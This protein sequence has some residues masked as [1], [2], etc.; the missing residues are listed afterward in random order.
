[1]VL[2]HAQSGIGAAEVEMEPI[3]CIPVRLDLV[4]RC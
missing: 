3:N 2:S 4:L 1:M